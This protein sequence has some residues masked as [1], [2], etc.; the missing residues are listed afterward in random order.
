MSRSPSLPSFAAT[1]FY[2]HVFL[3]MT[4][5]FSLPR[6]RVV[7]LGELGMCSATRLMASSYS[8]DRAQG[9]LGARPES[10]A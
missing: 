4:T 3:R 10:H 1:T 8:V 6:R 7:K 2:I 9:R 5:I